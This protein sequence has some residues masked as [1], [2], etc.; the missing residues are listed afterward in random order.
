MKE[1]LP[2]IQLVSVGIVA[3]N[4]SSVIEDIFNDLVRQTFPHEKIEVLLIDSASEDDTRAKMEF[5]AEK[6]GE[7]E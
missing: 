4:E 1:K 3:Y 5:F 6:N 7:E 2:D